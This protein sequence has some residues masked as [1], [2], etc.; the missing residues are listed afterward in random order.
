M[1]PRPPTDSMSINMWEPLNVHITLIS[2]QVC[3]GGQRRRSSLLRAVRARRL[4]RVATPRRW[5]RSLHALST[6]NYFS[7]EPI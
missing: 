3:P 4:H 2:D 1:K 6:I 7:T 5:R